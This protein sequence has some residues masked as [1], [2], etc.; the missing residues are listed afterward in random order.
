MGL[1]FDLFGLN[2]EDVY[3]DK[4]AILYEEGE[5]AVDSVPYIPR[6]NLHLHLNLCLH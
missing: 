5:C 1:Q 3:R 4:C 2:D 6:V